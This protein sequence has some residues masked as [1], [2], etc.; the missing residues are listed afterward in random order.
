MGVLVI[1]DLLCPFGSLVGSWASESEKSKKYKVGTIQRWSRVIGIRSNV[2]AFGMI[3]GKSILVLSRSRNQRTLKN[4]LAIVE[5]DLPSWPWCS[6]VKHLAA[7]TRLT[8]TRSISLQ[9]TYVRMSLVQ[10]RA[11]LTFAFTFPLRGSSSGAFVS[12][13][14]AR[15]TVSSR[16]LF[17]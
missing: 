16:G 7:L 11:V 12:R 15:C 3:F 1:E 14:T 17:A 13:S 2:V 10:K 5:H 9:P 6:P 4:G 8:V